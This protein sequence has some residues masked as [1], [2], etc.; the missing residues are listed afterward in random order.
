MK[1]YY[2]EDMRGKLTKA[3]YMRTSNLVDALICN[4]NIVYAEETY[5]HPALRFDTYEKAKW[6]FE[7]L[8]MRGVISYKKAKQLTI[9]LFGGNCYLF[10]GE[11]VMKEISLYDFCKKW[12][13]DVYLR[14]GI[15]KGLKWKHYY[16]ERGLTKHSFNCFCKDI[17]EC[18]TDVQLASCLLLYKAKWLKATDKT[19]SQIANKN[20]RN[21]KR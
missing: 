2:V 6:V 8:A 9:G 13:K 5:N 14:N 12:N 16:K 11:V 15:S 21:K 10:A 18:K 3:T 20:K 1:G 4:K 19:L 7:D 17:G